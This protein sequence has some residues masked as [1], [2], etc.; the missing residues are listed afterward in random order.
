MSKLDFIY[1]L[2]NLHQQL[3]PHP[4]QSSG[5][6]VGHIHNGHWTYHSFIYHEAKDETVDGP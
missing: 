5:V 4:I 2:P 3:S 1:L 6:V